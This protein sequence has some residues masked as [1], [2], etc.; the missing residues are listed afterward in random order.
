VPDLGT[1]S[2]PAPRLAAG[3]VEAV[4][5]T[6][7]VEGELVGWMAPGSVIRA[8]LRL[9]DLLA[10]ETGRRSRRV[11]FTYSALGKER[12]QDLGGLEL[13]AAGRIRHRHGRRFFAVRADY[14]RDGRLVVVTDPIP[15]RRLAGGLARKLGLRRAQ[16][17]GGTRA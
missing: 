13:A 14:D 9:A 15:L 2:A 12:G 6:T 16:P 7:A 1:V 17:Q 11:K 8:E 4:L 3:D 5:T 10:G